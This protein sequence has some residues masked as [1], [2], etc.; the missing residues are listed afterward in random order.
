[1]KVLMLGWE[2]P[3]VI[4][5]GL[6]TA[7]HG[8]TKGLAALGTEIIFALPRPIR[9]GL[10]SHVKLVGPGA[11]EDPSTL[12]SPTTQELRQ[13]SIRPLDV[14]LYPYTCPLSRKSVTSAVETS[15]RCSGT[16]T[17]LSSKSIAGLTARL[18]G[19]GGA[20]SENYGQGLFAK[21]G[22]Y[23][24]LVCKMASSENFDVIHA[25]DWMTYPAAAITAKL[26]GK[27]FVAHVHKNRS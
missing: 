27:P 2:F 9:S 5:G 12:A 11:R 7:C 6:G 10:S 22:Q 16:T 17:P 8:L 26:T 14:E 21:V 13:V 25:H 24:R 19:L 1:M 23:A 20:D 18:Q 4:S 3:P 15:G